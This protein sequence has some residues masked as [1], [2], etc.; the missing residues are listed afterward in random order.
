MVGFEALKL[1]VERP[2]RKLRHEPQIKDIWKTGAE[3]FQKWNGTACWIT[4]YEEE[5]A[6]R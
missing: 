6:E 3:L 2:D 4:G 5:K 1:M